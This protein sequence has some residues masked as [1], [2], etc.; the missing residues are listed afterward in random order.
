MSTHR[1]RNSRTLRM[2]S[3]IM[4]AATAVGALT[5][6]T[7]AVGEAQPAPQNG[8]GS[9]ANGGA[10]GGLS[11]LGSSIGGNGD[12]GFGSAAGPEAQRGRRRGGSVTSTWRTSP[13]LHR[14]VGQLANLGTG[15]LGGGIDAGSVTDAMPE[16]GVGSL[17]EADAGSLGDRKRLGSRQCRSGSGRGQPRKGLGVIGDLT[18]GSA[19]EV[20]GGSA[21]TGSDAS[22]ERR[23]RKPR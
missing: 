17:G 22:G 20:G 12:A 2:K 14:R 9:S 13:R 1:A 19:G 4:V 16:L 5:I 10:N 23:C 21:D 11:G 8:L 7:P 3:R 15:S 6:A 18:A